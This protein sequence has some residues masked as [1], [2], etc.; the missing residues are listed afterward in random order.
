MI[1]WK[2]RA[3]YRD[4]T[5]EPA[6]QLYAPFKQGTQDPPFSEA[7]EP[8]FLDFEVSSCLGTMI[9]LTWNGRN[10]DQDPSRDRKNIMPGKSSS[11][12]E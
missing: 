12:A 11:R 9:Y 4:E 6:L 3:L 1:P 10:A 2:W 7:K 5:D 8:G